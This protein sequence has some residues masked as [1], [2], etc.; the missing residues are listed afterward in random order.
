MAH[1]QLNL[2]VDVVWP[3]QRTLQ[4]PGHAH[5]ASG[6]HTLCGRP[7]KD[8]SPSNQ[9]TLLAGDEL[10]CRLCRRAIRRHKQDRF[11]REVA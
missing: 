7:R 1:L 8:Y 9:L 4:Q 3:N 5:L 11:I 10:M 6:T 2:F